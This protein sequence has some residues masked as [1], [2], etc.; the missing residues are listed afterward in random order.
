MQSNPFLPVSQLLI[1]D[2]RPSTARLRPCPVAVSETAVETAG[3][4][5]GP[6]LHGPHALL[7]RG[8]GSSISPVG[9]SIRTGPQYDSACLRARPNS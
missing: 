4:E 5:S 1:P 6:S 3:L 8:T 7:V 9:T 2:L